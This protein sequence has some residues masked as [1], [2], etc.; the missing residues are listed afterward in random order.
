M[1][2]YFLRVIF[3]KESYFKRYMNGKYLLWDQDNFMLRGNYDTPLEI[4]VNPTAHVVLEEL[5]EQ[6]YTNVILSNKS[7]VISRE[8]AK[9]VGLDDL[10]DAFFDARGLPKCKSTMPV[11]VKYGLDAEEIANRA[12]YF[13]DSF[14]HDLIYDTSSLV[15]VFDSAAMIHDFKIFRGIIDYL[16]E[17][18]N[19][20]FTRAFE[21]IGGENVE[22]QK[23][24]MRRQEFN[25]SQLL[26]QRENKCEYEG[27][28][29]QEM[30]YVL[31]VEGVDSEL[32]V[33]P[34]LSKYAMRK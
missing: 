29:I 27:K 2:Y 3:I 22:L 19:H 1:I 24:R 12:I 10:F 17:K 30:S 21:Q 31:E 5:K 20:S 33:L 13:G 15:Q 14:G 25:L 9:I 6:G 16:N 34:I 18:D 32:I 8:K 7:A 23:M 28:V 4:T 11:Q 26:A